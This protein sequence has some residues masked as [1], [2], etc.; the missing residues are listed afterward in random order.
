MNT[1]FI[2]IK[3]FI[4]RLHKLNVTL[5]SNVLHF[6]INT[7]YQKKNNETELSEVI[8]LDAEISFSKL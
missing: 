5:P 3:S 7:L 6:I 8:D 4:S 1:G 2:T